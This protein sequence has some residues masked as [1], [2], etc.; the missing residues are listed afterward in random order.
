MMM[1][2][3]PVPT[4]LNF[5][6]FGYNSLDNVN[7]AGGMNLYTFDQYT[8]LTVG[9]AAGTMTGTVRIYGYRNS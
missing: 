8:D 6:A 1:P 9:V 2:N 4:L 5:Q 3:Q 7:Y